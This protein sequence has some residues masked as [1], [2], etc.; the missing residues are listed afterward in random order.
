MSEWAVWQYDPGLPAEGD[1]PEIP[2]GPTVM[3]ARG[4]HSQEEADE[5]VD[6]QFGDRFNVGTAPVEYRVEKQGYSAKPWRVLIVESGQQEWQRQIFDHPQ[7]GRVPLS[8][9]VAFD[10]KRDAVAWV[11]SRSR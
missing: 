5:A 10:R 4:F 11:E 1:S 3:L 7:M 8:G 6:N 2:E 9:P